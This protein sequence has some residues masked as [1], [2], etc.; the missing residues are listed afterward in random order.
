M[1]VKSYREL[2]VWQKGMDLVV[3]VYQ[4]TEQFPQSE[5]F[6]LT[7]QVRR[8]VVSIPSNIAEG[9]GRHSPQD[10]KRFLGIAY[11]SLQEVETQLI[12]AQRLGYMDNMTEREILDRCAE[13]ARLLNGLR[14]SLT[15]NN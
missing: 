5:A 1:A 8:A 4:V 2:V 10:F 13:V 3:A 6:G 11:G 9:Q 12:L 15:T 14:K 7:N